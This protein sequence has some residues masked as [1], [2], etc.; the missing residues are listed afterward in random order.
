MPGGGHV[1]T[2]PFSN[3]N[4]ASLF[5]L[6]YG[7]IKVCSDHF[8]PINKIWGASFCPISCWSW[9]A[10]SW[11]HG[12]DLQLVEQQGSFKWFAQTY[13]QVIVGLTE[14]LSC[15][16]ASKR[17]TRLCLQGWEQGEEGR[18][19]VLS[20]ARWLQAS[21]IPRNVAENIDFLPLNL[22]IPDP[23]VKADL[24]VT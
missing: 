14:H 21:V 17:A 2:K 10:L 18:G 23:A 7:P 15:R 12:R 19:V 22:T 13:N 8:W 3:C 1:H 24:A 5:K 11:A 20:A 16:S 4:K 6:L 9:R